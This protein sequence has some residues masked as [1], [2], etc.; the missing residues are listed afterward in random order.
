M[1]RTITV[2]PLSTNCYLFID[3]K[4]QEG[5]IIDPGDDA[6]KIIEA[7]KT[8]FLRIRYIINTHTHTDHIGA[9]AEIKKFTGAEIMVH[10]Q[11]ARVLN[12]MLSISADK[13]LADQDKIKVGDLVLKV[14]H[15]PGHTPGGICLVGENFIFSGDTLFAGTV[16][17]WDLPGGSE[18]TLRESIKAQLVPLND[19]MIV[20]PGHGP[21]TT[22]GKERKDNQFFK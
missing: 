21:T 7:L 19:D 13:F 2:G 22:I 16:G 11:D 18:K 20:Y 10:N 8:S 9:D 5:M 17:R 3:D 4:S 1:I 6:Q 15:T 12:M 14:L